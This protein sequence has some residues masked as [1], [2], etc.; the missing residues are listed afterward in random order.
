[1]F[2]FRLLNLCKLLAGILVVGCKGSAFFLAQGEL[3]SGFAT[4]FLL[5]RIFFW[6]WKDKQGRKI[7]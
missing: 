6:K 3:I 4:S 5:K 7:N 1:M 2:L